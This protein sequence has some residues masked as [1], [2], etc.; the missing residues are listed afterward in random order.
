MAQQDRIK[1]ISFLQILGVS[2][3]VLGHSLHEYPID[4]GFSTTFYRLFQTIRMPLFV[5]IS[6]FLFN[7]SRVKK[8]EL[9]PY[10][11][12]FW[13]KCQRLLVPYL[14]LSSITF[15]PRVMMSR[16]AEDAVEL[17]FPQFFRSLIYS[18]QLVIVYFWFLPAIFFMLN[19]TY[20]GIKVAGR[21]LSIFYIA[22]LIVSVILNANIGPDDITFL[23]LSRTFNLLIFFILGV[24]Y[25]EY[26]SKLDIIFSKLYVGAICAII[27]LI[28][29]YAPG[30][31][32]IVQIT[33]NLFGLAM[34]VSVS[35][36]LCTRSS[37]IMHL[38][39]FT[40]IIY[41]LSWY[42]CIASQQVLHL[43][44]NFPWWV[45][46]VIAFLTSI[47]IPWSIGKLLY[48]YAPTQRRARVAL[49]LLGHNP[50]RA[51]S[52]AK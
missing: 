28:C 6:G 4:N 43:F 11:Q 14:F 3:V 12:F 49:W 37:M 45:Y 32:Y 25:A 27:W 40:Y 39:G 8:G 26:K 13:G 48:R 18:D 52:R 15:V 42:T 22:M 30:D 34:C 50:N 23:S 7:Y 47:Y 46:S 9:K 44:T 35:L 36:L 17:S 31:N 2:L 21:H 41:L 29:F 16:Y 1:F 33:C 20:W 24:A 51:Q 5:F 10:K 19:I 38:E